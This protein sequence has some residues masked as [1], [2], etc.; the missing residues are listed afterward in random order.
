MVMVAL[1]GESA[2]RNMRVVGRAVFPFFGQGEVSPTGLGDGAAV[3]HPGPPPDGS[4]FVLVGM[5]YGPAE[6][7]GVA[8]IARQLEATSLCPEQCSAVTA[9]RPTDVNNYA[10]ITATPLALA[11]VLSLFAVATVAHLLG[12]S[13]R[14]RRH[15]LAVLKTIGFLRHQVSAAVAW[16]ASIVVAVAVLIGLPVGVAAGRSAWLFFG[17]RLGVV[18][19][20]QVPLLPVLLSFPAALAI[21]NAVAV[22]PG[23]LA[24]RSRPAAVLRA[25]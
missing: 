3:L 4:N 7:D 15:D 8:R 16:Q 10:R 18:P 21:A 24:G 22:V 1:Q 12:T 17:G 6:H 9:Q 25:G 23:W 13:I 5:E 11:A 14:R 20:P 2:A 19:D